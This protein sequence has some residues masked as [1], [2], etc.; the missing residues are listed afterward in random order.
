VARF[1]I[2]RLQQMLGLK[3]GWI[4]TRLAAGLAGEREPDGTQ[5]IGPGFSGEIPIFNYGQAARRRLFAQ[6]KQTQDRLAQLEI[7]VL[8]E[9]R[10]AH[11]LLMNYLHIIHDY[12]RL[13][14]MQHQILSSAEEL[15][16]VMGL[17]IDRLLEYKQQELQIYQNDLE[18][19][20]KYLMT[21]VAL[22]RALGGYL[23]QLQEAP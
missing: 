19:C 13:L 7:Q 10:E 17:G 9:V 4:Y 1:E 20:K 18:Y 22:D 12:R 8:A 16:N 3:A 21:R 23:F 15:Y 14:P 11:Q 6:L 2:D 5:L